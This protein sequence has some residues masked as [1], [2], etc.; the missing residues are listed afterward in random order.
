MNRLQDDVR[1]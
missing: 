1:W